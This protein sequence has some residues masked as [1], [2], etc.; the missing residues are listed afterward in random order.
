MMEHGNVFRSKDDLPLIE[1]L[2]LFQVAEDVLQVEPETFGRI[3]ERLIR[4]G[5]HS[6]I[7]AVDEGIE[8]DLEFFADQRDLLN[9]QC[10][11]PADPPVGAVVADTEQ[12][13]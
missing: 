12:V 7:G 3:A 10:G 13:A 1:A 6:R 4:E 11:L 2:Y 9:A 5:H 8:G